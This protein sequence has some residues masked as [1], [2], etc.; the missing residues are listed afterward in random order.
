[1]RVLNS[2]ATKTG[3]RS[4]LE[5]QSAPGHLKSK[6]QASRQAS[7]PH[8]TQGQIMESPVAGAAQSYPAGEHA[9]NGPHEDCES[10]CGYITGMVGAESGPIGAADQYPSAAAVHAKSSCADHSDK[11]AGPNAVSFMASDRQNL[12]ELQRSPEC[13]A[14]QHSSAAGSNHA[15]AY[16]VHSPS[17]YMNGTHK[18]G[19]SRELSGQ[20]SDHAVCADLVDSASDARFEEHWDGIASSGTPVHRGKLH[21]GQTRQLV[22]DTQALPLGF[23]LV[24]GTG[25]GALPRRRSTG[26]KAAKPIVRV[27]FSHDN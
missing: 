1:M 21:I 15:M 24:V 26:N 8:P 6:A 4:H 22:E 7:L 17:A 3:S 5:L 2:T 19:H 23:P 18:R 13:G 11:Q 10:K 27:W 25:A 12:C 9:I 16:P 20:R 14:S